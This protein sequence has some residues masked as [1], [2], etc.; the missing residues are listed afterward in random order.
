MIKRLFS[1]PTHTRLTLLAFVSATV[2]IVALLVHAAGWLPMYFLVNVLGPLSLLIL[3][4]VGVLGRRLNQ[5]V[6]VNR[7]VVGAWGGLA[8]TL[9]YDAIRLILWQGGVFSYNPFLSHPIFGMLITGQPVEATL[10]IIVG[11]AYHFWNGFGFGIMYTLIAGNAK[12]W[13]ALIWALILEVGWLAA[14]PS[15]LNFQ[16]NNELIAISLI[17]HGAYGVALGLLSERF[18]RE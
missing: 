7:L 16:L 4:I 6:F 1:S 10:S 18:I 11:W 14:L 17:G 12:W 9:A 3:L 15:A 2:S 13:Y 5:R 8:A